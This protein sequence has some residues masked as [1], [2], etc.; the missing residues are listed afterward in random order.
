MQSQHAI[1]LTFA[2]V[3]SLSAC[4]LSSLYGVL[5]CQLSYTLSSNYFIDY[6][7]W[8]YDVQFGMWNRTGAC[9]V[10]I[11]GAWW[12]GLVISTP[13]LAIGLLL[14][15]WKLYVKHILLSY[16]VVAATSLLIGLV[17]LGIARLDTDG[18]IYLASVTQLFGYVGGLVGI[19]TGCAYL[20]IVRFRLKKLSAVSSDMNHTQTSVEQ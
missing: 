20:F 9:I 8:Q 11:R 19:I 1:K 4:V 7:F 13:Q 3:L 14:P 15:H 2:P 12:M 16:S 18:R 6:V 5:Y 17:A 10:G